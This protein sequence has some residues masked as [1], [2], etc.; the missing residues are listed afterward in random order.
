MTGLA[1]T[2]TLPPEQ[3]DVLKA[4]LRK[5][6]LAELRALDDVWL[7]ADSLAAYLDWPLKRVRNFTARMPHRRIE[8][9]VMF[10]RSEVDRWLD[11]QGRP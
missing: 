11:E 9:R 10:R 3:V 1:L 5:E 7:S 8:G 6:L 4:E 2:V